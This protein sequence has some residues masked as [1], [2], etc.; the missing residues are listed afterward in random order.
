MLLAALAPNVEVAFD[1]RFRTCYPQEVVDMHF[2]FL[3]GDVGEHRHRNP[4]SGPI[5]PELAL[6]Y[7]QPDLVLIDRRFRHSVAV[8]ERERQQQDWVLLYQDGLAQVWGKR[9]KFDRPD[10]HSYIA[11]VDRRINDVKPTGAVTWPALPA[12]GGGSVVHQ[13][14]QKAPSHGDS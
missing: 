11:E 7:G 8:M 9:D 1:G 14:P 12:F 13:P 6:H 2:D 4:N 10:S 3:I 5:D